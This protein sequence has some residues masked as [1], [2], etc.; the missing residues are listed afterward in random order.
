MESF[1]CHIER[2]AYRAAEKLEKRLRPI[3][4]FPQAPPPPFPDI[5]D[6]G[7]E[8]DEDEPNGTVTETEVDRILPQPFL[9]SIPKWQLKRAVWG[10]SAILKRRPS[11]STSLSFASRVS[12]SQVKSSRRGIA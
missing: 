12:N 2:Q 10:P 5:N 6:D 4:R 1:F 3:A 9:D 7:N 8:N 11:T